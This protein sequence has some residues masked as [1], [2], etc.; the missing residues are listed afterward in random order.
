[1]DAE[2][3]ERITQKKGS[4]EK[5]IRGIELLREREIEVLLK[6]PMMVYNTTGFEK[7]FEYARIGPQR[8][9]A[10]SWREE[11]GPGD[12]EAARGA[13]AHA[14]SL[15]LYAMLDPQPGSDPAPEVRSAPRPLRQHPLPAVA[16]TS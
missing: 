10:A 15:R 9:D 3:F 12:A 6:I 5:T 4:F 8:A 11:R 14:L 7:I 1:M 2:I 13:D 16:S